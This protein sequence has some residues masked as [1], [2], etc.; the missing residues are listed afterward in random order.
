VVAVPAGRSTDPVT[1]VVASGVGG[2][3]EGL[4]VVRTALLVAVPLLLV[5]IG[6]LAWLVVGAALRPVETLRRGAEE[7]TGTATAARL[8]VPTA[9]DE[10]HR[11]AVTLNGML[12][13]LESARR[14]QRA[15]VADAAHEL[16]SPLASL[17]TQ[18][19]VADR[20]PGA[21]P[22]DL[23]AD[24]LTDVE[25]LSRLVDDLLVLARLDEEVALRRGPVD[26]AAVVEEVVGRYAGARVPVTVVGAGQG[27][28]VDGDVDVLQ[29]VLGNLIDNAVR[30]ASTSVTAELSTSDADAVLTV[31]DDGPG[32]PAAERERVFD[33][34]TRLDAARS[35]LVDGGAGGRADGGA[36]GG[37]GGAGL[38]L[39]I[40]RQ[41]V[42]R[43]GG[44]VTLDDVRS[45]DPRGL[46]VV[47][48]LPARRDP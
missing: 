4:R 33:R 24:L 1:V 45:T 26:L 41:A 35:R 34:F 16:R 32:V 44:T 23:T 7:I 10:V 48:R 8:P 39:A 18:L 11:L 3:N 42:R 17:R 46:R 38:G 5:A 12:D 27:A 13:R 20:R 19:E 9:S 40:V 21:L 15:F 31:S 2:L 14:H 36:D 6:A 30:H 22:P 28:H 25:R 37:T 43:H 29:R 47:V